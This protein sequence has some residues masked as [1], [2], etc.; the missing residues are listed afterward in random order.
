[1]ADLQLHI[2]LAAAVLWIQAGL[3]SSILHRPQKCSKTCIARV[4]PT[5]SDCASCLF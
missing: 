2:S 1:M 3:A 5:L 4:V